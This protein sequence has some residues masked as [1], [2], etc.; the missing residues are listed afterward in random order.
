MALRS[1]ASTLVAF[2]GGVPLFASEEPADLTKPLDVEIGLSGQYKTRNF[3][4]TS[5]Q[6]DEMIKNHEA[7]G[8]DP[9]VD[10]GH[11]SWFS[12]VG[13]EPAVGWVRGLRIEQASGDA[14]RKA[15]VATVELNDLGQSA[16]KN[17][18]Y[19]YVSMGFDKAG[20]HRMS[21]EPIGAVLDH[22]AL[23][24][25]PFIQGMRPLSLALSTKLGRLVE[26]EPMEA[27]AQQLRGL[28]GLSADATEEQII[29]A[30]AA[31]RQKDAEK[32][33]AASAESTKALEEQKRINERLEAGL[34]ALSDDREARAAASWKATLAAKVA[35]F[36]IS[37]AEATE[38]EK[39]T[40]GERDVAGR[41]LAL[42][43]PG[44]LK[45]AGAATTIAGVKSTAKGTSE[46][47]LNAAQL[48]AVE[49]FKKANPGTDDAQA[50]MGAMRET[51]E[52]FS[53]EAV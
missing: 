48:G 16:V 8:V 28:L 19:R 10:R 43:Q 34:K 30:L 21:G 4:L 53:T 46:E 5:K 25:N 49:A 18:H 14:R 15:L 31:Q 1:L 47:G 2:R 45:P 37:P 22:L 44:A 11:E 52:L 20:K 3:E 9:A 39:L 33:A 29:A 42:R 17:G 40:G 50:L 12:F 36:T 6:F 32:L 26:E 7:A 24:K 51:P 13:N 41:L 35:E 27:L 38:Q 23:V